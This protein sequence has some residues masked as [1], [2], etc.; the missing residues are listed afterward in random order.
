M[1]LEL[2]RGA[3]MAV[4]SVDGEPSVSHGLGPN[5]STLYGEFTNQAKYIWRE[6]YETKKTVWTKSVT[7]AHFR[8]DV[9]IYKEAS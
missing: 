5:K 1:G 3:G 4:N 7:Y 2:K 8:N 6:E 9:V